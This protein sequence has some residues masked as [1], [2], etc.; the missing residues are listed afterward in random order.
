[1]RDSNSHHRHHH[2]ICTAVF[3]AKEKSFQMCVSMRREMK[4]GMGKSENIIM[5]VSAPKFDWRA[6]K[7]YVV[8]CS[9]E[10]RMMA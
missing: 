8:Y 4:D 5:K 7:M 1:M 9:K 10:Y 3:N 6:D 2:R